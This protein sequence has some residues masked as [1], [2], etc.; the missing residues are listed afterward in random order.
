[1]TQVRRK[2]LDRCWPQIRPAVFRMIREQNAPLTMNQ[3]EAV[4]LWL[5]ED[6]HL[7][8]VDRV[9]LDLL[10]KNAEAAVLYGRTSS[11]P[12]DR[13]I[14]VADCEGMTALQ[15]CR[16]MDHLFVHFGYQ[17]SRQDAQWLVLTRASRPSVLV[18]LE[19]RNLVIHQVMV[20]KVLAMQKQRSIHKTIVVTTGRFGPDIM[21]PP[22]EHSMELWDG[23]RL[24][25]LLDRIHLSPVHL[26][27]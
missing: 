23:D 17:V 18:Y 14:T 4:R 25:A 13:Y 21:V 8:N 3:Y 1:M 16:V 2:L 9:Y 24:G 6:F 12:V 19:V 10:I 11:M 15:F 26:L 20:D 5:Q 27:D 7:G 22:S